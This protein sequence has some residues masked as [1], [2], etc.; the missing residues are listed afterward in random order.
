[1]KQEKKKCISTNSC[2]Q[3]T[4]LALKIIV[5]KCRKKRDKEGKKKIIYIFFCN[6]KRAF[7]KNYITFYNFGEVLTNFFENF[8]VNIS[9]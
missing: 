7:Q 5:R 9:I 4:R 3:V 6:K 2:S 8:K 1:M